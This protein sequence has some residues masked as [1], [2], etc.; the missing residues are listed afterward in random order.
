VDL[1]V[2][3]Q[4]MFQTGQILPELSALVA[5]AHAVGAR[6][7]LD[8]Y[9]SLGVLPVDV[10]A[11]DVDFAVG[12][13]YKYL[14][15]G[16]GACFLYVAPRHLDA[17][18]RTLDTGWF[19]KAAPFDYARPEPPR[20]ATGGDGWLESTPAVLPIYQA[21]AGQQLVLALGVGRVRAYS[22]AAQRRLVA[23][24]AEDGIAA[25][26]GTVDRGAFV[27]VRH[28]D[29]RAWAV[30]LA[31]RAIATDARGEWLRLAPDILTTDAEIVAAAR[32]LAA[33]ARGV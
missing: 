9:H 10:A 25:Q 28:R 18:L 15:G 6:V 31:E 3:S 7:L 29:A 27:V 32:E 14:R 19:A 1:V 11:P 26:G 4:V 20:F 30:A 33:V 8:V 24:L 21:R 23:L 12:G 13:A 16:P 5:H 2:V 17:G 22:L